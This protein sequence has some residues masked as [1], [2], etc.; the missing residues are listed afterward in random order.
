M[1]DYSLI[2]VSNKINIENIIDLLKL[3]SFRNYKYLPIYMYVKSS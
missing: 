2:N 3:S 1:Q